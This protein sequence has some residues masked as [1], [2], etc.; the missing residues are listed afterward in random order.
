MRVTARKGDTIWALA[1]AQYGV[2]TP[3][4]V[5]VVAAASGVTDPALIFVGQTLVF[6]ALD[7]PSANDA[8]GLAATEPIWAR[9]PMPIVHGDTLWAITEVRY[10]RV[11]AA[12]VRAVAVYNGIADPN[13]I[14]VG[15][16]L[17]LPDEA[18]LYGDGDPFRTAA[19]GAEASSPPAVVVVDTPTPPPSSHRRRRQPPTS[20]TAGVD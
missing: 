4:I 13:D 7:S 20:A 9:R 1:V 19:G 2:C 16:V 10:G 8:I 11:D 12:L 3:E 18:V 6:P 14:P 5:D 15:F 17:L